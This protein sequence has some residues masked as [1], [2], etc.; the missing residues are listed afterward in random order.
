LVDPDVVP[1]LAAIQ[2]AYEHEVVGAALCVPI[3]AGCSSSR[4]VH[5]VVF[6]VYLL[7]ILFGG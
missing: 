2:Q 1:V 3:A 5:Q 6:F 7:F 4:D